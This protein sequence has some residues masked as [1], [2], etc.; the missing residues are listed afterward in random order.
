MGIKIENGNVVL[1]Q[2]SADM[3]KKTSKGSYSHTPSILFSESVKLFLEYLAA[4]L[5]VGRVVSRCLGL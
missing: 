4:S 3:V 1:Q 2:L 5:Y